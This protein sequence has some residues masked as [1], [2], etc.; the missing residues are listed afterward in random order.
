MVVLGGGGVGDSFPDAGQ[1]QPEEHDGGA[2]S[3]AA[4]RHAPRDDQ[5]RPPAARAPH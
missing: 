4:A 3:P 2:S 5:G 1:R